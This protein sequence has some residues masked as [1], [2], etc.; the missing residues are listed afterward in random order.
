MRE[1]N[2]WILKNDSIA[3]SAM[4]EACKQGSSSK[5]NLILHKEQSYWKESLGEERNTCDGLRTGLQK[6]GQWITKQVCR[7]TWVYA[8]F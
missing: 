8:W 5:D 2:L 1:L 7:T 3:P 4:G 6:T